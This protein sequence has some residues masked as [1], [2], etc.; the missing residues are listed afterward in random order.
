MTGG[1]VVILGK[2]GR[3]FGAGMSGGVAYVW[4]KD[5]DFS[6]QCNAETYDL[7]ALTD[8]VT[9]DEL[10]TL[11]SKHLHYTGSNVAREILANWEASLAQFV[12]VMPTDYKRV[13]LERAKRQEALTVAV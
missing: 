9:I 4:D 3:N 12:L 10:K 13:V 11:I 2:T 6:K 5:K 8:S 7:E 1:R